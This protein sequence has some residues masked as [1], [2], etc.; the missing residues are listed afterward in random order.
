M[1]RVR[2]VKSDYLK[3]EEIT[4]TW[5]NC[6]EYLRDCL[7]F[8]GRGLPLKRLRTNKG[9][10]EGFRLDTRKFFSRKDFLRD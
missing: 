3:K 4:Q 10:K 2:K 5:S 9:I 1:E 8:R 6:S 7:P